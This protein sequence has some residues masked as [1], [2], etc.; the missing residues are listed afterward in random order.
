M[1]SRRWVALAVAL[2]GLVLLMA[3][4]GPAPSSP[5]ARPT[6]PIATVPVVTKVRPTE[7]PWTSTPA[8]KATATPISTATPRAVIPIDGAR[9][10][11]FHPNGRWVAFGTLDGQVILWDIRANREVRRMKEHSGMVGS[12]DFSADG[13]LLASGSA[14]KTAIVWNA[15]TG[16]REHRLT[17]HS[18]EVTGVAFADYGAWLFTGSMDGYVWMWDA[19]D[20]TKVAYTQGPSQVVGIAY[21]HTRLLAIAQ[22][23]GLVVVADWQAQKDKFV[24]RAFPDLQQGQTTYALGYPR[25]AFSPDGSLLA[26][27]SLV[28]QPGASPGK[29]YLFDMREGQNVA[30]FP[31][32]PRATVFSPDGKQ[33]ALGHLSGAVEVWDV[34]K[35]TKSLT[36]PGAGPVWDLAFSPDGRS[37]VAVGSLGVQVWDIPAD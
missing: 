24:I 27:P 20:G 32:N 13:S 29:A 10:V 1:A 35:K 37:L 22:Q 12:V 19:D 14:D 25:M 31:G 2:G 11:A 28:L 8:R 3:C 34:K 6:A 18:A 7:P 33:L 5:T 9:S 16:E 23:D 30:E 4:A 17:E 26:C 36:F 21:S 15:N